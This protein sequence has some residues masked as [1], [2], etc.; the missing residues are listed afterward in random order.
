MDTSYDI[1]TQAFL[2][3]IDEYDLLNLPFENSQSIT[4]GYFRTACSQFNKICLY[5]LT[6]RD[7]DM[8]CFNYEFSSDDI[9][10]IVDIISEGMV[11]QWLKPLFYKQE[12]Y[13]NILNTTDYSGYSPAELLKRVTEAYEKSQRDFKNKMKDYSYDHGDL[14]GWHL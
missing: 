8:R 12:N 6:N 4:D 9:D 10:E 1:F 14:S 5:N 2:R 7:E 3:K 11:V 13:E